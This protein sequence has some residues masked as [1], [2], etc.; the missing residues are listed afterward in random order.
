[1]RYGLGFA[2][3]LFLSPLNPLLTM[4]RN[5]F[6]AAAVVLFA[7]TSQAQYMAEDFS[8]GVP[9]TGWSEGNNGNSAGWE[10]DGTAQAWHADYTGYNLNSLDSSAADLTGSTNAELSWVNSNVYATWAV[11]NSVS[12][13]GTEV[14]Y[15]DASNG[16]SGTMSV[17]LTAYDGNSSVSLSFLYEGD[18]ANDWKV[19]DV[20]I[21]APAPPP[22]PSR[23]IMFEDFESGVCPPAG[24]GENNNGNSAGWEVWDASINHIGTGH[25]VGHDDFTGYNLNSVIAGP[26]Q[27]IDATNESGLHVNW[28]QDNHYPTWTARNS[29]LCNGVEAWYQDSAGIGSVSSNSAD[30]SAHDGTMIEV[31]FLYDGDYAN[32]WII[33]S[34]DLR[35]DDNGGGGGL[36]LNANGLVA[37]G[38]ATLTLDNAGPGA[39]CLFAWSSAGGGPTASVLGDVDLSQPIRR[40]PVATADSA[41]SASVSAA[42]PAGASGMTIWMQAAD[43]STGELSPSMSAVV[44]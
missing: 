3:S 13:N 36:S 40:L 30:L 22:P 38:T 31:E 15:Q 1:M 27:S 19:D 18:Y 33:D 37:G 26:G 24:W 44:G 5:S 16:A 21:D 25:A 7:G 42:V 23:S 9:P 28:D 12:V 39:A 41:G 4:L 20:V 29:V 17:D 34:V 10:D 2:G 35:A 6:I 8:S 14:W 11:R 32:E 43:L